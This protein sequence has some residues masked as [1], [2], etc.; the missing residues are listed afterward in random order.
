MSSLSI[1]QSP[2]IL[3]LGAGPAGLAAAI[4]ASRHGA[5]TLLIGEQ[6]APGG[7]VYRALEDVVRLR[8]NDTKILGKD[9]LTGAELIGEFRASH[10]RYVA[11]ATVWNIDP[12]EKRVFA[13]VG[14]GS[15]IFSPRKIILATGALERPL[16]FPGWTLPGVFTAGAAQI[17][18]KSAGHVPSGKVVLFGSGPLLLLVA[19]QLSQAGVSDIT[20]LETTSVRDYMK[21]A[22]FLP[23]A[24]RKADYLR[25]GLQMR[26]RL[27]QTGVRI[28]SGVRTIKAIGN[29]H[30]SRVDFE[31]SDQS[32]SIEA[33]T[34]FF[35]AG[36]I[37]NTQITRLVGA[38]H[39]WSDIQ[40][41]WK[42]SLTRWGETSRPGVFVAGD[43]GGIEGAEVAALTGKISALEALHQL[44]HI[45]ES[46][47]NKT[48]RPLHRQCQ[49]HR[50]LRR[51]LD[52][53]YPAPLDLL[54]DPPSETI[55][56]RCWE[57]TAGAIKSSAARGCDTADEV[58]SALRCGMGPCQ[59][60]MCGSSV[61]T[62][63]AAAR[64][65]ELSSIEGFNIRAPLKPLRLADL[66]TLEDAAC[67]D[68]E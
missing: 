23:G 18:L 52:T 68:A 57:V 63:I 38:A 19:S 24:L 34:L 28:F 31:T 32:C 30:V 46:V 53:L 35:H 10:C 55:I 27:K 29:N 62:L 5:S 40:T 9:Y 54:K 26:R 4:T 47:R 58:K 64:N 36:V 2:E 45:T 50:P 17:M 14:Q 67:Q 66:A 7:Q 41:A 49:A 65:T 48:A 60:R 1:D 12:S 11:G 43:G 59:G 16:P 21:A 61:Q 56:C 20:L 33:D 42:P 15:T 22:P 25:K 6:A 37:P 51:F 44:G 39:E 3:V 8:Q 13:S